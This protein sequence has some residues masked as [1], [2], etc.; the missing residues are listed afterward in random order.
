MAINHMSGE[1]ETFR[2]TRSLRQARQQGA[3][4]IS[5]RDYEARSR[6]YTHAGETKTRA[7]IEGQTFGLGPR[8][9]RPLEWIAVLS[10]FDPPYQYSAYCSRLPTTFRTR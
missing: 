10:G 1:Y 2:R 3:V 9:S 7:A 6:I 8:G 5:R 4:R